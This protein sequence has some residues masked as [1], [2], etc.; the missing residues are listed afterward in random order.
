MSA[1][2]NTPEQATITSSNGIAANKQRFLMVNV[3]IW[4][5]MVGSAIDYVSGSL[6]DGWSYVRWSG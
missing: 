2:A 5:D 6:L 1:G 3:S 4:R